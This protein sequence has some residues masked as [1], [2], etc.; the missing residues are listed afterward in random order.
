MRKEK[1]W[2]RTLACKLYEERNTRDGSG[3][4]MDLLWET[5][6]MDAIKSKVDSKKKT[7]KRWE[8]K[9]Y[10]K[11]DSEDEEEEVND[12]LCCL[13]A[14]KFSAGKVNLGMGIGKPN[15]MK[16]SKAIKGFGWLHHVSSKH[17][18]KVHIEDRL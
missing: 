9:R 5:Y 15:L 3:E 14:L 8:S 1:E 16:I 10:S 7:K 4:G 11:V 12:Q 6:E 18:K 13:Q 2:K 17:S